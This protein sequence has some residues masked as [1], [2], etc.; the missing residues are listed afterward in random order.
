MSSGIST[1]RSRPRSA[2]S[3]LTFFF[4]YH[5]VTYMEVDRAAMNQKMFAAL[6]PAA[7]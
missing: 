5:D 2:D 3:T 1:I 6:K 7:F 4:A